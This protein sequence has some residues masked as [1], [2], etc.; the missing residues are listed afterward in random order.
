MPALL[1]TAAEVAGLLRLSEKTFRNKKAFLRT[2]N[3][4]ESLD[5]PGDS[6]WEIKEIEEWIASRRRVGA[7]PPKRQLPAALAAKPDTPL[8]VQ[9]KRGRGRPP[10]R[11]ARFEEG[12]AA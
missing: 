11:A 8:P 7:A 10:K 1:A 5:I 4:P 12:G 2:L 6:R 9:E 3:F